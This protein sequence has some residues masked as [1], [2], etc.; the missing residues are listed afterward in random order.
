MKSGPLP[1]LF[2]AAVL[3]LASGIAS[4]ISAVAQTGLVDATVEYLFGEPVAF[5][6]E[7]PSA[8]AEVEE[9]LV[10]FRIQ[11]EN[12]TVVNEMGID[13]QMLEFVY[14]QA[15]YPLRPFA[16]VDYWF[17]LTYR[18]A[19]V[20]T[21]PT[22]SFTYEDN[23]FQW[24]TLSR[25]PFTVHWYMGDVVFAQ[26][27]LDVAHEG[28][29]KAQGMLFL[30]E[31]EKV[32]IYIYASS[33]DLQATRRLSRRDGVAGH[34]DVDLSVLLVSLPDLPERRLE[35]ERQVPHEL[36]H[37]MLYQAV[38]RGYE[39]IPTWL[40]EGLAS[41]AEL[42]PNPDYQIYLNSAYQRQALIPLS[43]LCSGF[44]LEVS[45]FILSYAESSSFTR[46]LFRSN[47][48]VHMDNLVRSYA[49]GLDCERGF[50]AVYGIPL[51]EMEQRWLDETFSSS[52]SVEAESHR[53]SEA[54]PWFALLFVVLGLPLAVVLPNVAR[55]KGQKRGRIE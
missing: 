17:Q 26:A 50:E 3:V 55:S 44:P 5:R 14:D 22:Y 23:R 24:R 4:P 48:S 25:P 11:G 40:N 33:E 15:A 31:P 51:A 9:A 49:S 21:S 43:S 6:A 20:F 45:E 16:L 10:L 12:H 35:A 27:V 53:I 19:T 29:K 13:G 28:M 39:N 32:D 54:W 36:M 37:V 46:Y 18:D 2:L 34:A 7:L 47:G 41:V 30:T 52:A 1:F 8:A 38:E 42:Y